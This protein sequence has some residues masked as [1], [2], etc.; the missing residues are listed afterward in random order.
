MSVRPTRRP[1][2]PAD[3]LNRI[4]ALGDLPQEL[5][6][7]IVDLVPE[8]PISMEDARKLRG[9]LMEERTYHVD[10]VNECWQENLFSF[11]KH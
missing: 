5:Q 3:E 2:E 8:F 11:C 1:F 10:T 7:E 9:E 6:D 4:G